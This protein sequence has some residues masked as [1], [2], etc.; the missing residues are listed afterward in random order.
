MLSSLSSLGAAFQL[1]GPA[2]LASLRL[3]VEQPAAPPATAS[4]WLLD[5]GTWLNIW[6]YLPA[7]FLPTTFV[8]LL[9]PDG[10]LLSP[11]WRLIAWPA[12]LG[13][14]ACVVG[15]ALHPGPV[16]TWDSSPNPLGI[17][18]AAAFLD[19]VINLGSLLLV[20]GILGSA[21]ALVVRYRRSQG[22]VRLQMKW[23]IYAGL[24]VLLLFTLTGIIWFSGT[25]NQFSRE[26]SIALTSLAILCIPVGAGVAIL[27]YRLY[28]IDLLINRSLVYGALTA[29]VLLLYVLLVGAM[30]TLFQAGPAGGSWLIALVATGLVAVL[31]QP[32]RQRLQKWVNHLVYGQRDEPFEVLASLG[33]RLESTI[34]PDTVYPT[35]VETV[36]Q[37]LKLPYVAITIRE[38]EDSAVAE[39]YGRPTSDLVAYSLVHQG[40]VAGQLLVARRSPDE[41]FSAADD[42]L[43]RNIA[44]QAGSAVHAVQLTADLQRSRQRLVTAREEERRRLRRDLHDGLG[45]AL[46]ALHIQSGVLRRLIQQDPQAAEALVDEF[47]GDIRATIDD[48]RRV[49]DELRP[50]VL[51]ALGL[52]AAVRAESERYG[53]SPQKPGF[54]EKPLPPGDVQRISEATLWGDPV[55][56]PRIAIWQIA[57]QRLAESRRLYGTSSERLLGDEKAGPLGYEP[58]L[59]TRP[60]KVTVVVTGPLPQLPAAVEV[61]AY[62]IV[63]EALANVAKHAH[64]QTCIIEL[65][66]E[67]SVLLLS[68]TDNGAGLPNQTNGTAEGGGLGLVSMRE[69]AAELGGKCQITTLPTGGTRVQAWLPLP[70][71]QVY[72]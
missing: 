28:D 14:A 61:A 68:V 48:I 22:I 5:F 54:I 1:F 6:L 50:P 21:A 43:L 31:F 55:G 15:L 27:R 33:Q 10:R 44:R 67:R 64:A 12:A 34:A 32:L 13:L 19:A 18:R 36:A 71:D 41:P 9:F 35:I 25:D 42:R 53:R 39:S 65:T 66:V 51:D 56:R 38:G 30:S 29:A 59:D 62:R 37:T 23:L 60:P 7:V 47:R 45:P 26:L 24:L 3:C 58:E 57:A 11:R 8:F 40:E 70:E 17:E 16:A 4:C 52:E 49:V 46:A 72:G 63:Q 20:I 69:R 2:L